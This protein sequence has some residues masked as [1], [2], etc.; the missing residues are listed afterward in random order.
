MLSVFATV[1]G[2]RALEHRSERDLGTNQ[3]HVSL[4]A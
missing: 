3:P 2:L 1:L 4:I